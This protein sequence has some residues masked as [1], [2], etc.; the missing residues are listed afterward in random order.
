MLNRLIDRS[1][2]R[3]FST[4]Y[5]SSVA[6]TKQ[7]IF[8]E[9][10]TNMVEYICTNQIYQEIIDWSVNSQWNQ[11]F[12]KAYKFQPEHVCYWVL[13][14]WFCSFLKYSPR[15]LS[16]F[17]LNWFIIRINIEIVRQITEWKRD[18]STVVLKRFEPSGVQPGGAS[19]TSIGTHASVWEPLMCCHLGLTDSDRK[20]RWVKFSQCVSTLVH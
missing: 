6:K 18:S 4:F 1:V 20:F 10:V 5:V 14:S 12:H 3:L 8:H 9:F 2:S 11:Y 19:C 16:L 7:T 17:I 13:N 15:S